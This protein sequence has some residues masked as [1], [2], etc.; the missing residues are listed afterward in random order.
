MG[1]ARAGSAK[2]TFTNGRSIDYC[3]A[4]TVALQFF[5]ASLRDWDDAWRRY[6]ALV[7][8]AGCKAY[9]GLVAAAGFES[10]FAPGTMKK[11]A[12]AV[13]AWIEAQNKRL[14]EA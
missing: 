12:E 8:E 9:P 13:G 2:F 6:I 4:Q 11:L 7:N 10:P 14:A 3:L 1:A 5:I